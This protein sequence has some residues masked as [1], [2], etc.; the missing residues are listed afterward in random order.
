MKKLLVLGGAFLFLVLTSGCEVTPAGGAYGVYGEYP[1]TYYGNYY[2]AP[3][4]PYYGYHHWE[5]YDRDHYW[6][7]GHYYRH[8]RDDWRWHHDRD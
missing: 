7:R 8:D 1:S 6:D 2:Y 5:P 4:Y 3:A